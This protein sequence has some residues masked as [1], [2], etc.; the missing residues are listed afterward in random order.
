MKYLSS[1]YLVLLVFNIFVWYWIFS[2][3]DEDFLN[4]YFLDIGQGDS[5]LIRLPHN[6]DILVDGGRGKEILNDLAQILSPTDRYI[7][8]VILSHPQLDHFGGLIPVLERYQ[9]GGFIYNG[10]E[11]KAAAWGDLA[12]VLQEKKIPTLVLGEKDKIKYQNNEFTFL[13][14]NEDFKKS[15]DINEASLV[16]ELKSE[17]ANFLFTGDIDFKV[18]DY[19]V[20]NYDIDTDI[21]KV[22][23]HGSKYSSSD[24]FLKVTRPVISVIQVGKNSYGH[25]TKETLSRLANVGSQIFRNDLNGTINLQVKDGVVNVFTE[26]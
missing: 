11:G 26:R 3:K 24:R 10:R 13:S 2:S 12:Q 6:V 20:K 19:L 9:V 21:L 18:E 22:A 7:D 15:K 5:Q 16:F 23:H 25:P 1:I 17:E 8:L 4:L 14:P